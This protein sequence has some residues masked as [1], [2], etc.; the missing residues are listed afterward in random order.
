M[1]CVAQHIRQTE[2]GEYLVEAKGDPRV[3]VHSQNGRHRSRRGHAS[4]SIPV[5]IDFTGA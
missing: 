4:A 2:T 1:T 3:Q 5:G